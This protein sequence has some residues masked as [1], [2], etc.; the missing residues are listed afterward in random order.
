MGKTPLI[1]KVGDELAAFATPPFILTRVGYMENERFF[2][3]FSPETGAIFRRMESECQKTGNYY[4]EIE[5]IIT[6]RS[7]RNNRAG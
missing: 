6:Y 2:E 1:V 5:N 7:A 3:G 4:P